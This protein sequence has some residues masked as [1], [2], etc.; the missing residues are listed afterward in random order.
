MKTINFPVWVGDKVWKICPKC[1]DRHN[2]TC[3]HCAWGPAL[4]S[5]GCDIGPKVYSDGS[6]CDANKL[7]LVE[8]TVTEHNLFTICELFGTQYF[9]S[10]ED[11]EQAIAEYTAIYAIEDRNER[12]NAYVAWR[13]AKHVGI[14]EAPEAH[15][16]LVQN[17]T[18]VCSHCNRQDHIDPLASHCRY[19]GAKISK[20]E[21][22]K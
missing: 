3:E 14:E 7:Q 11:A 10:K 5:Y 8:R 21:G 22:T 17:G 16:T 15:W 19:C 20:L 6:G 18:G 1:N 2:G 4:M 9:S 13:N 12:Y